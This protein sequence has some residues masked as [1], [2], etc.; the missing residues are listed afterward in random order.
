MTAV[1]RSPGCAG[2]SR[3]ATGKLPNLKVAG[4][5]LTTWTLAQ[6]TVVQE[7]SVLSGA[8]LPLLALAQALGPTP[9]T[10]L[11][12]LWPIS[13][14]L[15][16]MPEPMQTLLLALP[17]VQRPALLPMLLPALM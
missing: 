17:M 13:A 16:E 4:C 6:R 7:Q 5:L 1:R 3:R 8:L 9:L 14:K 12:A 2:A 11:L 15:L 10:V